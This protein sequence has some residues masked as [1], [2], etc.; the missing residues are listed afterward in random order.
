MGSKIMKNKAISKWGILIVWV[1]ISI[2]LFKIMPDINKLILDKGQ[3][4]IPDSYSV[5]IAQQY[6]KQFNNY[7]DNSS[8]SNLLL[9][10]NSKAP[11]TDSQKDSI[12]NGMKKLEA[13]KEKLGIYSISIPF[14]NKDLE[15]QMISGDNTT[16]IIPISTDKSG[17]TPDYIKNE[18]NSEL[19]DVSVPY[20]ITGQEFIIDANIKTNQEGVH[21]T[22]IFT[23][24]IIFLILLIVFRS[25]ITPL[26][27]LFT[28]LLTYMVSLGLVTQ[29]VDKLNFPFSTTTQSFLILILFGIGTDYNIL[30]LSRFK[31]ELSG[32]SIEIAI[33]N[34]YKTAGKTVLLSAGT[35]LIGF[36]ILALAKF[37]VFKSASAVAIAVCV[38]LLELFTLLP[39]FMSVLGKNIFLP[40]NKKV[41]N[42]ENKLWGSLSAFSKAK[43]IIAMIIALII[44]LP[45]AF[46]YK[47]DVSYDMLKDSNSSLD[48]IKGINTVTEKFGQGIALPVTVYLKGDK[49]MNNNQALGDIDKLTQNLKNLSSVDKVFS[50]TRPKG[51]KIDS[52]YVEDQTA[53]IT[54]GLDKADN[55]I[56]DISKAL[57]EAHGQLKS[58]SEVSSLDQLL[59]GSTEIQGNMAALSEGLVKVKEGIDK[60]AEGSANLNSGITKLEAS[61]KSINGSTAQL[62]AGYSK[63]YQGLVKLQSSYTQIAQQVQVLQNSFGTISSYIT[64][65]GKSQPEITS[66]NSYIALKTMATTISSKMSD[67]VNGLNSAN[68]AFA[69]ALDSLKTANEGLSKVVEGQKQ[70]ENGVA[71]LKSGQAS[72][73][74]GLK[75]GSQGQQKI[76][77]SN[78]KLT[79]AMSHVIDGQKALNDGL[80][81]I[82][83]NMDK[84][85]DG[86]SKSVDGLNSAANGI[87]SANNYLKKFSVSES[88][89]VFYI[90]EDKINEGDFKKSM[91]AYLS[92]NYNIAKLTILLKVDPY[93]ES[94]ILATDSINNCVKSSI[95]NSSLS[96]SSFGIAGTA[97]MN[98]DLKS[99]SSEDLLRTEIIM[100]IGIGIILLF[101]SRSLRIT[102]AIIATLLLANYAAISI[103]SLIFKYIVH[104]DLLSWTV[105]FY[106]FIMLVALGVDYSIFLL[107]QLKE[108]HKLD[109]ATAVVRAAAN[110]GGVVISAAIILSGTF[111]ALYPANVPTLI[112]LATAVII[113]LILLVF[114]L[115][116]VFV[117]A[118]L[119]FKI[120]KNGE[121]S[122]SKEN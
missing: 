41:H 81:S 59:N 26:V 30:L 112:E 11:L 74:I 4:D 55:G 64:A 7:N 12:E 69:T 36:G 51:D 96:N 65:L 61:I 44:T 57:S 2:F 15:A 119:S 58:N 101:I 98:R 66:D 50:V 117:P 8:V 71:D 111:A 13:D 34:T 110:V 79:A 121:S 107:M 108:Q 25:P 16:V 75:N 100:L 72:L 27:S 10:F 39:F 118:V 82:N 5:K 35:V 86:L 76:I 68:A 3:P 91:D 70:I 1:A 21:K 83:G 54:E 23:G 29:L 104:I 60:G 49:A 85:K 116:P 102:L 94:G 89:K 19:K 99:V 6:E 31:K 37:S 103:T 24:I 48:A 113:G 78:K 115:L 56:Q 87:N 43:P 33:K 45:F 38:L 90:P 14:G 52:L 120:N 73:Y 42:E 47:G 88:T 95:E 9:V 17:R 109:P 84:L 67:L 77:E 97:S 18:I 46:I 32:N 105:P 53:A 22:E 106:T 114:I 92:D 62:S 40:N 93:S 28:I 122:Y 63:L 80:A 20:N